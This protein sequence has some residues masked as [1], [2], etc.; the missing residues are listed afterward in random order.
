MPENRC[1]YCGTYELLPFKCRYCGG[2]YCSAHRLPEYHECPG[3]VRLKN[4]TWFDPQA[5]KRRPAQPVKRGRSKIPSVKLPY[6]GYY[7]YGII[8]FTVLVFILQMILGGWFTSFFSLGGGENLLLRPWGLITHIFLH[9]NFTHIF[10]NMLVLFFFGPLLERRIGTGNFLLVF[11]ASGI[12]AGLAQ[13]MI[14]PGTSVIGASGAIFGVMGSLAVLMPDL[15][16]YL[17]FIPMKIVYAVIIFAL[18]DL[19]FLPTGDGIA[20]AAH[21]AGLG[22]GLLF[23]YYYKKKTS[24]KRVYW[25]V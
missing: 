14:F 25:G 20:H 18:I 22:A 12:L 23:G 2:T 11:F 3:L 6:E 15:V 19:V 24:V 9:G 21:L 1:D 5:Q 13:V 16:I 7:A 17:Y 4:G 10:F 8:L